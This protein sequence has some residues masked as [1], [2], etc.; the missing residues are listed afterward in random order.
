M[1]KTFT[2]TSRSDF[3]ID[4][5][6]QVIIT[7]FGLSLFNQAIKLFTFYLVRNYDESKKK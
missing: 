4:P 7:H 3:F 1:S 6:V 2:F 5:M